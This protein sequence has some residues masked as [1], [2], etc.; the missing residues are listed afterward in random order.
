MVNFLCS[1]TNVN[2]E[3]KLKINF[4]P[5]SIDRNEFNLKKRTIMVQLWTT[6]S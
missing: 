3:I 4:N 2:I 1:N 5:D 6:K